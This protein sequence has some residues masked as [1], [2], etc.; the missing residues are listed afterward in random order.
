M[1]FLSAGYGYYIHHHTAQQTMR[2]LREI[3]DDL[4]LL[5]CR[6]CVQRAS[7][8]SILSN[9]LSRGLSG[10]WLWKPLAERLAGAEEAF[11]VCW[12]KVVDKLPTT[13]AQRLAPLGRF[14]P[15]GGDILAQ[16]LDEVHRELTILTREQQRINSV[17]SRLAAAVCFSVAALFVLVLI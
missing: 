14:L 5:R 17:N 3:T 4:L 12:E 6:V 10:K 9:D 16:A 13:V 15:V 7:L 11:A 1:I 8:P 2:L